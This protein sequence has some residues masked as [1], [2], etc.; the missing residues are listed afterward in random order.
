LSSL[1]STG[2]RPNA[3]VVG[4]DAL[5]EPDLRYLIVEL[6]EAGAFGDELIDERLVVSGF[7]DRQLLEPARGQRVHHRDVQAVGRGPEANGASDVMVPHR[8]IDRPPPPPQGQLVEAEGW[9]TTASRC[10]GRHSHGSLCGRAS[11]MNARS[12]RSS[13]PVGSINAPNR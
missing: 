12:T 6:A 9:A 10:A 7:G 1:T 2:L 11:T 3:D 13:S 8:A 5:G 4:Y